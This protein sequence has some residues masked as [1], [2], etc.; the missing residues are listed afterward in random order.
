MRMFWRAPAVLILLVVWPQ[1][2]CLQMSGKPGLRTPPPQDLPP[3]RPKQ[4]LSPLEKSQSLL[5]EADSLEKTGR[6]KEAIVLYEKL[7]QSG[8]DFALVAT[9]RLA[10]IYDRNN[11][12]ERAEQEYQLLLQYDKKNAD[13]LCYLGYVHYRRGHMGAAFNCFSDATYFNP[14]HKEAWI[15]LAFTQAHLEEDKSKSIETFKRYF[16]E[17]EAYCNVAFVLNLQHKRDDAIRAYQAALAKD[18][19]M[20]RARLELAKMEASGPLPAAPTT[21]VSRLP[22]PG[23]ATSDTPG[24]VEL[25]ESKSP[26]ASSENL[27]RLMSQRPT[28]PPLPDLDLTANTGKDWE[29]SVT[30]QKK[31]N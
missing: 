3:A 10:F 16:S 6:T 1:L 8:G 23:K 20:E 26:L 15:N 2:G 21:V 9:K 13:T 4:E 22:V 30:R 5:H 17:A 11:D 29:F 31:T 7:R 24:N 18:P 12:L 19:K 27:S 28:L 14:N 25:E